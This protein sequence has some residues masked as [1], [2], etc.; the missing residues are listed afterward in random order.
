LTA[1]ERQRLAVVNEIK[2]IEDARRDPKAVGERQ[3]APTN[4]EKLSLDREIDSLTDAIAR[5]TAGINDDLIIQAE[6]LR[7][8]LEIRSRELNAVITI[9]RA[10]LELSQKMVFSENQIRR[11]STITW[12]T[13]VAE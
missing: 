4:E 11:A 7:T 12:L 8:I 9:Q 2:R 3:K 10:Q 13:E 5:R 6:L 1:E